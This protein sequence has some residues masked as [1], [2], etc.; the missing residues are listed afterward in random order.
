MLIP[1]GVAAAAM[2]V[3][4]LI[5]DRGKPVATLLYFVASIA[6]VYGMLSMIAIPLRVA[7]LGSC[8]SAPAACPIGFEQPLTTGENSGLAIGIAMG[9]RQRRNDKNDPHRPLALKLHRHALG[10]QQAVSAGQVVA[11]HMHEHVMLAVRRLD[12]DGRQ[13]ARRHAELG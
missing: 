1:F 7:V 11:G 8:P 13:L 9:R 4:A 6:L 2:A 12:D 3:D 5:Y 10:L